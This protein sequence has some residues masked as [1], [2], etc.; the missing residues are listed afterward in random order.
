[1]PKKRY[2]PTKIKKEVPKR[3]KHLCE[4]CKCPKAYSPGPFDVKHIIPLSKNG[5]SDFLNLAYSC[6]GCN[7]LKYNKIVATD[8]INK[9]IVSIFPSKKR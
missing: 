8:P 7:G 2:I 1:M 9:E 3:A 4:Y 5:T 6:S